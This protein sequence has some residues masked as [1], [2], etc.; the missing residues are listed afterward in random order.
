[1][2]TF[3]RLTALALAGS[4]ILTACGGGD[5]GT[6]V[7]S[8]SAEL[9]DAGSNHAAGD[10]SQELPD[11][12]TFLTPEE[13]SSAVGREL[14]EGEPQTMVEGMSECRFETA[15]GMEATET[16]DDP[17]IPETSLG[18]VTVAVNASDP[19]E[20]DLFEESLGAEA[21][22]VPRVGDDAY[23]WGSNILYVRVGDSGFSI[24]IDAD[25]AEEEKMRTA[26]IQLAEA[27]AAKL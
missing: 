4:L 17:L 22:A 19:E 3:L 5:R 21:E 25:G 16:Y 27:G 7:A 9:P 8:E 1:M 18:S 10:A 2:K 26:I 12:C 23:F 24:R 15:T 14:S 6:E 11:A 20:F 13:I